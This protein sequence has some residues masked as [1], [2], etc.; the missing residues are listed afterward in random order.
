MLEFDHDSTK[1]L[2]LL[3]EGKPRAFDTMLRRTVLAIEGID[4][5]H[6]VEDFQIRALGDFVETSDCVVDYIGDKDLV[7]FNWLSE[8]YSTEIHIFVS[9][10]PP[11]E[12]V[13]GVVKCNVKTGEES[14]YEITIPDIVT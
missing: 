8:D 12:S 4:N 13:I 9:P 11:N 14:E 1:H 7:N 5:G 3:S 10:T 6:I 2:R